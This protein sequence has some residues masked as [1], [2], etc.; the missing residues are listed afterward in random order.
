M[1]K[2]IAQILSGRVVLFPVEHGGSYCEFSS[3]AGGKRSGSYM[4][5]ELKYT[6]GNLMPFHS[7]LTNTSRIPTD[8]TTK[9]LL[10]LAQPI[11]K[12]ELYT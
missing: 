5:V 1:W 8:S 2:F 11:S 12:L 6:N 3:C 9:T 4:S 7:I 10:L